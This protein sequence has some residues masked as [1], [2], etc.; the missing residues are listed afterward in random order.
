MITFVSVRALG[1]TASLQ[2]QGISELEVFIA[3]FAPSL[4]VANLLRAKVPAVGCPQDGQVGFQD[5]P[6]LPETVDV[7]VPQRTEQ[8]LAFYSAYEGMESGILA[9]RGWNCFGTYGSAGSTLYVVPHQLSGEILDRP[10]KVKDG[11]A[12]IKSISL[13]DTSGRFAVAKIGGR[14][15]PRARAF[16]VGVRNEGVDDPK[17]FVFKPWPADRIIYLS[18]YAASYMTPP[19]AVGLGTAFGLSPGKEQIFGLVFLTDIEGKNG[20]PVLEGISVRL[21]QGDQQLYPPIGIGSIVSVTLLPATQSP[22]QASVGALGVV[23]DFYEALGHADGLRA[24]ER[25]VPEKRGSGPFSPKAIAE[26]YSQL[27]EPLQLVSVTQLNDGSVLA[28]YRYR[29]STGR[30]C[31]GKSLVNLR[32]SGGLYLIQGIQALNKC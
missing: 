30:Y 15:F 24:S 22:S 32:S 7:T 16:A 25:V 28:Q 18:D 17:D 5:P 19:G 1:G 10:E 20:G 9:P 12:V 31:N 6:A 11:F 8:S 14:I 21:S 13:G 23:T 2:P 29:T 4:S 3:A 26:F 27:A